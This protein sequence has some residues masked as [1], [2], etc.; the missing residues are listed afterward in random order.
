MLS[1]IR[2]CEKGLISCRKRVWLNIGVVFS[3]PYFGCVNIEFLHNIIQK[4]KRIEI[5]N[6][7]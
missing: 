4:E 7:Q 3:G 5:Q 1:E 2:A 6:Q